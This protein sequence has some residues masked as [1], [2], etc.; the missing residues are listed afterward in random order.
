MKPL[1][2][3]LVCS[4]NDEKTIGA[5]LEGI[6]KLTYSPLEVIVI[7]DSST[8]T[9]AEIISR[10]PVTAV[11]NKVNRGLGFNLNLGLELAKGEH[12]AVIQSD[13]EITDPNWLDQMMELMT[14]GV[15]VVV[16]QRK[17]EG[18]ASLPAGARYF[19]AVAPQDLQNPTGKPREEKFA[20]GKADLYRVS[21]LR[22]LNGWNPAFFTAGEDTDLSFRI[23]KLGYR[24]LL[25][26]IAT[27]RYLFSGR[28]V[29]TK[30]AFKKAFLYGQTAFL[31]YH[32]HGYDGIQARTYLTILLSILSLALPVHA[33]FVAGVC[34]LVYS[35]TCGIQTGHRKIPFGIFA[36]IASLILA[37][38]HFPIK[39]PDLFSIPGLAVA[40]VGLAYTIYLAAKNSARNYAKG[41][42]VSRL[43]ATFLFCIAW[44]FISGA[45]YVFGALKRNENPAGQSTKI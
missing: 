43:P 40:G 42:P 41:E 8:D 35:F 16:S 11:H 17:I 26:P 7:N 33:R 14:D 19:N 18:F 28:Q 9:T 20:R 38:L 21:M 29:S 39:L 3:V 12:L 15:G 1:V 13:C 23:R 34:L 2:T 45:G 22:E 5:V 32:L 10:F 30:G 6:K 36:F 24:I 27:I 4:Y 44:R 37:M 31:L 25:S